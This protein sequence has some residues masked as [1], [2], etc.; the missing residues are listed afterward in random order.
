MNN[1]NIR[2][3]IF[4]A[5]WCAGLALLLTL[6]SSCQDFLTVEPDDE[7]SR[8]ETFS[9]LRGT[10]AAAIGLYT[11]L[12]ESGL[13]RDLLLFYP[14][15]MGNAVP[16]LSPESDPDN[17]G[18]VSNTL[19]ESFD[20]RNTPDYEDNNL[21]NVYRTAYRVIYQAND[22]IE[23]LPNLRE[24]TPEVRNRIMAEAL[25]VRALLHFEVLRLFAHAYHYS[26]E[27]RHPGIV[28]WRRVPGVEE[29]PARASVEEVY[30]AL[31][32]DLEEALQLFGVGENLAR[33]AEPVWINRTVILGLLVR[34]SLYAR[35]WAA[36]I[37]FA[38]LA[39][40]AAPNEVLSLAE[41]YAQ[42][43]SDN[44]LSESIWQLDLSNL[45][46][47]TAIGPAAYLGAGNQEPRLRVSEDCWLN[48]RQTIC[49]YL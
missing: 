16:F 17:Q 15:L 41:N 44:R 47:P 14:E 22:I 45:Q 7:L 6:S 4:S 19:I 48:F 43:W 39:L 27:Q 32:E 36:A 46:A 26:P 23:N 37:A 5:L 49:E 18:A 42:E 38:D 33:S 3:P 12:G 28:L 31:R 11:L 1:T 40:T 34:V 25:T 20:F 13:Y 9:T 8:S 21:A 24:G 10:N 30:R 29:Q 35:D 2:K